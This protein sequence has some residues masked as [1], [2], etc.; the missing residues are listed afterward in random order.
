MISTGIAVEI[1][2]LLGKEYQHG[3]QDC[4][5][6][7]RHYYAYLGIDLPDFARDDGW[8]ECPSHKPLYEANFSQVGF[9]VV[10]DIQ[11][12]DVILCKVGKTYHINH[13]LIYIGNGQ[14]LHHPYGRLSLREL[15][16]ERWQKRMIMAIRHQTLD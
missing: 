12:H 10:T 14:I 5:S 3:I 6:L 9:F 4:Y 15:F 2:S 1:D 7:V 8:W 16:N 13:A 11:L